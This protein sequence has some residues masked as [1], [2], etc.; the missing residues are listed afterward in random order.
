VGDA[1]EKFGGR[2]KSKSP[3]GWG[4]RPANRCRFVTS[5]NVKR[6]AAAERCEIS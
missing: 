6:R 4:R 3:P 2:G 5:V 1:V